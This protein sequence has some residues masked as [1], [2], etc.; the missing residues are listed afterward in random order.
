MAKNEKTAITVNDKEYF[1]EDMTDQQK[2]ML[3]HINDLER[4]LGNAQFN[5]DQLAVG[6]DAFVQMLAE[7][8]E[9]I[10]EEE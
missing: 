6:R 1:V 10:P 7:S 4:K 5:L 9:S 3:T 2:T 8:L